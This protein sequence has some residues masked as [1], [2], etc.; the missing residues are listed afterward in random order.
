[1]EPQRFPMK[2]LGRGVEHGEQGRP[3]PS[4]RRDLPDN[5]ITTETDRKELREDDLTLA[6]R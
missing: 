5:V 6:F 4:L 3:F 1:M 2:L